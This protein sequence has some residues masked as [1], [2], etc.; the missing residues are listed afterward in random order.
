[1]TNFER[2][3]KAFD[4]NDKIVKS[5]LEAENLLVFTLL[6]SFGFP[7]LELLSTVLLTL[8]SM[9]KQRSVAKGLEE[10][11]CLQMVMK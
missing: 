9:Q 8:K 2:V 7:A 6:E 3:I 1:M 10:S 11:A 4:G 5:T